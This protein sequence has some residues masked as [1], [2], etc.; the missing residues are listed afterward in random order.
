MIKRGTD[1]LKQLAV[2]QSSLV[3]L[4]FRALE[5]SLTDLCLVSSIPPSTDYAP[6]LLVRYQPHQAALLKKT[7]HD[8]QL[9]LAAFQ[10][11]QKLS[12]ERQRTVVQV[13]KQTAGEHD[14][15]AGGESSGTAG[16]PGTSASP[17]LQ[18]TQ[19]QIQYVCIFV[20]AI[21]DGRSV[22][23]GSFIDSIAH[24]RRMSLHIRKDWY[25]NERMRYARSRLAYTN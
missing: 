23:G 18:Q 17:R 22:I 5:P 4:L 20:G 8:F 7:S 21:Y 2:L 10:N 3:R 1:D 15:A 14:G 12:A 25:K 13:V 16:A 11:A 24:Y 9:S 19:L 6:L